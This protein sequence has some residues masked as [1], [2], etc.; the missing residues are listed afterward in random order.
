[1]SLD[2]IPT[3]QTIEIETVKLDEENLNK[4]KNLNT[5]LGNYVTNFGNIY[6]RRKDLIEEH[7]KIDETLARLEE[8]FKTKNEEFKKLMDDMDDK[9]PGGR[10]NLMEGTVQYQPGTL[11]RKQIEEMQKQQ[12]ESAPVQSAVKV[13]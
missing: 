7:R 11:S 12:A 2:N 6:L 4:I 5:E 9:Y 8:E 10:L 1:M 3:K 13:D